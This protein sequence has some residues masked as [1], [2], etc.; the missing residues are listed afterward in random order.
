[1]IIATKVT[2]NFTELLEATSKHLNQAY[3]INVLLVHHDIGIETEV[4]AWR[5]KK[6][7]V[8]VQERGS[9]GSLFIL[10]HVFG[11]LVQYSLRDY[12]SLLNIV[13]H[14]I[15]PLN[16]SD[17]F[18]ENFFEYE[19]EAFQIGKGLMEQVFPVDA[20]MDH[21]YQ[22]FMYAD[23]AHYWDYLTSS[24]NTP[25]VDRWNE[26]RRKLLGWQL[27]L[28]PSISPPKILE[29]ELAMEIIVK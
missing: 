8:D 13:N 3:G 19:K 28:L 21:E 22:V 14:S 27:P 15:P 16:L 1:M 23:F 6:L 10:S 26:T 20:E 17:I 5:N 12:S 4:A 9:A 25:F 29:H 7:V 2:Q 24:V 18:K 11:H